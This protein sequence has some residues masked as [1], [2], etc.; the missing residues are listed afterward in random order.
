MAGATGGG[1]T[2][3]L[4]QFCA[5]AGIARDRAP[6]SNL[7]AKLLFLMSTTCFPGDS[8]QLDHLGPFSLIYSE[9]AGVEI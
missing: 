5:L 2:V 9:A 8:N 3:N 4:H 1:R 7:D 6:F